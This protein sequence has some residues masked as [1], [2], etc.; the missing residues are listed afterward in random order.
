VNARQSSDDCEAYSS[1]VPRP[2]GLAEKLWGYF[3][4]VEIE[5]N[6]LLSFVPRFDTTAMIASEMPVAI[7]HA[8]NVK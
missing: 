6:V 3:N 1:S 7:R 2:Q 8:G 4:W 5:L